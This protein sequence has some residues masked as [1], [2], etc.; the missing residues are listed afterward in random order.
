MDLDFCVIDNIG[1]NN[2]IIKYHIQ[3]PCLD[4]TLD[5]FNGVYFFSKIDLQRCYHQTRLKTKHGIYKWLVMSFGI[6]YSPSTFMRLMNE[7]LRSLL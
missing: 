3:I 7:M 5:G 6:T 1:V 2:T 4:Y